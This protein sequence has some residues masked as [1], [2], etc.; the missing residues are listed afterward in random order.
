[1]AA[2][3]TYNSIVISDTKTWSR[4]TGV[5]LAASV[6]IPHKLHNMNAS[7]L[8]ACCYLPDK[9]LHDHSVPGWDILAGK[10][11][12]QTVQYCSTDCPRLRQ[13]TQPLRKVCVCVPPAARW[14]VRQK[15]TL[16]M[17]QLQQLLADGHAFST[18]LLHLVHYQCLLAVL[19][20]TF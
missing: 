9:L 20:Y 7:T 18:I 19:D 10:R 13:R 3:S 11:M 17:L 15:Q 12:P 14:P 6:P 8:A 16:A 4:P 2:N 1:M 5:V